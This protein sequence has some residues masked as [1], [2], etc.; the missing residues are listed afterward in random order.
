MLE[1]QKL[2]DLNEEMMNFYEKHDNAT[3]THVEALLF[4]NRTNLASHRSRDI[5]RPAIIRELRSEIV[6]M[7]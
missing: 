2:I 3:M 7:I 1:D 5:R 4:G 6:A